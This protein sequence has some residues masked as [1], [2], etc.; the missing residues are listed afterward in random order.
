MLSSLNVQTPQ[1]FLTLTKATQNISDKEVK[2]LA[3][4][5]QESLTSFQAMIDTIQEFKTEYPHATEAELAAYTMGLIRGRTKYTP[6]Y[7]N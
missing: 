7:R 5:N 1:K 4:N 6:K 3:T 2:D